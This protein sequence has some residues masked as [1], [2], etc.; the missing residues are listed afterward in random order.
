MRALK[1]RG[2]ANGAEVAQC[3]ANPLAIEASLHDLGYQ[4]TRAEEW[5]AFAAGKIFTLLPSRAD[6][7]KTSSSRRT[8][9]SAYL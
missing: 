5:P 2:Y 6:V 7:S 1:K 3:E 4:R 9:T 8:L